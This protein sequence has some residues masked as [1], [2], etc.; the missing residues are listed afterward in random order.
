M[1]RA[2]RIF[3]KDAW[4]LWPQALVFVA[5]MAIA[6]TRSPIDSFADI[7]LRILLMMSPFLAALACWVLTVSLIQE[8]RL[9]GHEQYWLTRPYSWKDLLAAKVLFLLV[10][11]NLPLFVCQCA[12]LAAAGLSPLE[13]LPA[14]LWRQAFFSMLI[15]LPAVALGAVTRHFGQVV[16]AAIVTFVL[17]QAASWLLS[18]YR[19]ADWGGLDWIRSSAAALA[20]AAGMAA[21]TLLQYTRR[22]TALARAIV[23]ATLALWFATNYAPA[24]GGAFAIERLFSREAADG[25]AVRVSFDQLRAGARPTESGRNSNDPDGVRLEIPLRVDGLPPGVRM[26]VD[27]TSA[28]I[29][30]PNG[31]WRSGWLTFRA[32]HMAH[33]EA[34]FTAYVEPQFYARNQDVPVRFRGAVDLTLYRRAGTIKPLGPGVTAVPGVGLC[35]LQR[36]YMQNSVERNDAVCFSPFQRLTIAPVGPDD[37]VW[38]GQS[39]APIPTSAGFQPFDQAMSWTYVESAPPA[40]LERPVAHLQRSFEARALRLRDCRLQ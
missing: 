7:P 13:W 39:Y 4:C 38:P 18:G 12:A 9:V 11:V 2:L 21:A 37:P 33:G 30:G 40:A 25:A 26:S 8:E 20:M 28:V 17:L 5:L 35:R 32:F 29:E 19:Y 22:R 24:W 16:L 15:V 3:R 23:A 27:W 1:T 14:L 6:A 36:S 31:A 10:F 34:W